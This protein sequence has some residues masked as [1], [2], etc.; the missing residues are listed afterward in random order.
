M[1]P[2]L[3]GSAPSLYSL[4]C[5]PDIFLARR[6]TSRLDHVENVESPYAFVRSGYSPVPASE[7]VF[8]TGGYMPMFS[9][10]PDLQQQLT[11]ACWSARLLAF[12]RENG[13]HGKSVLVGSLHARTHFKVCPV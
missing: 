4:V 12:L 7:G 11:T 3:N 13:T 6:N 1:L 2:L 5:L 8:E 9:S 10:S